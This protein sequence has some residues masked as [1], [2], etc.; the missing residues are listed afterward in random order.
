ML[1]SFPKRTSALFP[2]AA[3]PPKTFEKEYL[4]TIAS[5]IQYTAPQTVSTSHSEPGPAA[6]G[7]AA[8]ASNSAG[9]NGSSTIPPEVSVGQ[10]AEAGSSAGVST[11]ASTSAPAATPTPALRR[12]M[13][14]AL[15]AYLYTIPSSY[16]SILYISKV[17][18]S[19]YSPS[20][21]PLTRQLMVAFLGYHLDPSTRPSRN[22]QIS[23]FARS[24]SQYL[25]PN[26]AQA[27]GKRVS[28]G[29][30]LCGWW[31]GVYEEVA[32]SLHGQ[33]TVPSGEGKPSGTSVWSR[34][35]AGN[36]SMSLSSMY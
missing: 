21:L 2:Y 30:R 5:E 18:T 27:K 32:A 19:G 15:H 13:V 20:P 12:V 35:S 7:E 14:V 33:T 31:K 8:V 22:V 24:Q 23:L 4:I 28:G 25:F 36:G 16:T 10:S 1:T 3:H 34:T 17:D 9:M 29:L 11:S 6:E 26:S